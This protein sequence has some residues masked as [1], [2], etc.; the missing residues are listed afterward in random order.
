MASDLA[1]RDVLVVGGDRSGFAAADALAERGARVVLVD[2]SAAHT[3]PGLS[4]RMRILEVLGVEVRLG[5]QH[6]EDLPAG[7]DLVV[8]AP[9]CPPEHPIAAAA[10][11]QGTAVWGAAELA[12]R[13]RPDDAAPWLTITGSSG[14]STT[15]ALLVA[16]LR[17][18][19][20][21]VRAVGDDDHPV[22]EAVLD[23]E[24]VDVVV[25]TLSSAELHRSGSIS[26]LAS[27]C[28]RVAPGETGGH[29]SVAEYR[30]AL[31]TVYEN[32]R[33]ACVYTVEDPVTEDL[34]RE[35]DVVEGARAIGVTL[36]V[37]ARSMLGLVEDVLADRA[38]V[39]ARETT[40]AELGTLEDLGPQGGT[41]PHL[42]QNALA[43]AALA[44]A[45]GVPPVA[46]RAGL[47]EIGAD[48]PPPA[49]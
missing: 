48:S 12:W 42:V 9:G 1:G 35:A 29:R 44:R 13:L 10:E 6:V 40:A 46:V 23:P 34:V 32:T 24:P 49:G 28:L 47:R 21:R 4:E 17:A 20:L 18:A 19:G 33:L 3:D 26:P 5:P 8:A 39:E 15:A 45:V 2:G 30:S 25:V 22:V 41:D 43:A 16:M 7:V 11:E 38:F 37:P 31:G 27:V 36:G 14:V